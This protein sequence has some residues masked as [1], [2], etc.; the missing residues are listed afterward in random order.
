M[1]AGFMKK[2]NYCD[3]FPGKSHLQMTFSC[4]LITENSEY[5]AVA[6]LS[7]CWRNACGAGGFCDSEN[8]GE[9]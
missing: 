2:I 3:L 1:T 4:F 9:L 7:V 6:I 8:E 5:H